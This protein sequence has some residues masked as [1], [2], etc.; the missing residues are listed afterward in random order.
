[1]ASATWRAH[2]DRLKASTLGRYKRQDIAKWIEDNTFLK[3]EPFSFKD[4]EFQLRIAE[5][6][7]KSVVITK[8]SQVGC[9]ELIARMIL[10]RTAIEPLN[11]IYVMPTQNAASDFAKGRVND[12]INES[13][14]LSGL[15]DSSVDNVSVKKLGHSFIYFKGASK[16]S[17]AISTPA[18]VIVADEYNYANETVVKQY[19]SRLNHSKHKER[20][21]FS[22]PT[23]PGRGVSAM[24]DE[25]MQH[26]RLVKCDHCGHWSWPNLPHDIRVPGV[27]EIDW[28]T[29]NKAKLA[30]MK[31]L[32]AY[33]ACPKC[34]KAPNYEPEHREWVCRNP[35]DNYNTVGYA[36][37]PCDVPSIR[38]AS[39]L[40]YERTE[41][42]RYVDFMNTA[43]GLPYEDSE[44][45]YTY[46]ELAACFTDQKGGSN[47]V[48]VMGLD[49]GLECACTVWAVN[50][51][52]LMILEHVEMIPI[53]ILEA[54][55]G[56]IARQFRVSL[57]VV[58]SLPYTDTVMRMQVY[59]PNL[60]ASVYVRSRSVET[61]SL[62]RYE[63]RPEE[64]RELV[65]Q[66]NINR[67][68]AFDAMMG[69]LR[70][71]L[72]RFAV[73]E[74]KE[75]L[76]AHFMDMTRERQYTADNEMRYTWVKSAKGED[77]LAHS[78]CMAFIGAKMRGA[79]TG[80]ATLPTSS[81]FTFKNKGPSS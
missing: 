81:V 41:Y 2:I 43:C 72:M 61:Y 55:R 54:R 19:Q 68:P 80:L 36:V 37:S 18:D 7:S 33:F 48:R 58:D 63:D 12:I 64:G 50:Y 74:H 32:E 49:M 26:Y 35:N 34:G 9:S 75:V 57:T 24:F 71:G 51:D 27:V 69:H 28:A 8:P 31:Y 29:L 42:A 70:S 4:H 25:A 46:E 11:V 40:V 59:D 52:G 56:E 62:K 44:S 5:E 16:D 6:T 47:M 65:R 53:G 10:A 20:I 30:K 67:D 79:S 60:Y 1:M 3:G 23:L 13:S 45:T 66:V 76:I 38:H 39:D 73:P 21:F 17:Q 15:I 77:H 14:Y 78:S 22:T